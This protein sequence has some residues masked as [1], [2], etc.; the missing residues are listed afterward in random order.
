MAESAERHLVNLIQALRREESLRGSLRRDSADWQAA[1]ARID[2]LS[3]Q[4]MHPA[5]SG[6]T[7]RESIGHGVD[8]EIDSR[9]AEDVA[10]RMSVLRS[11]RETVQ[12]RVTERFS[13]RAAVRVEATEGLLRRT[14]AS[15]DEALELLRRTYPAAT[16][17]ARSIPA[18]TPTMQLRA[19][20][21]GPAA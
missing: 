4:V 18:A 16:I 13:P 3:R 14:I 10:F 5:A 9:P 15:I 19:H 1:N 8:A 17:E 11:I 2:D 6:T 12:A 7:P 21:N 20:R